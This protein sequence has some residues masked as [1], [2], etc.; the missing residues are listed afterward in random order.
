MP[1]TFDSS[2]IWASRKESLSVTHKSAITDHVVDSNHVIGWE[3]NI[4][5]YKF[6]WRIGLAMGIMQKLNAILKS[7]E[8]TT[9]TKLEQY[10]VLVLSIAT[11]ECE[12]WT[13][14]W[15]EEQRLLVLEKACLR[16]IPGV[17]RLDKIR[18]TAIREA[19]NFRI[20]IVNRV[21]VRKKNANE[22]Y[23]SSTYWKN[24][25]DTIK[26]LSVH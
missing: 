14:K 7:S 9:L 6:N 24:H 19:M 2:L 11:Y 26:Y 25:G 5:Q 12:T 22:N 13:K 3:E 15:K 23:L 17:T 8:I 20:S 1:I 21:R 18:N 16:K 4:Y 10:G